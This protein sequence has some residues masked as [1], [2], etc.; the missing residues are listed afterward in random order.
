MLA[1]I[2]DTAAVLA[3][4]HVEDVTVASEEIVLT[5]NNSQAWLDHLT[6]PHNQTDLKPNPS[7]R[8]I[9]GR[10]IVLCDILEVVRGHQVGDHGQLSLD[11]SRSELSLLN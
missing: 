8:D 10:T 3:A 2:V 7:S 6:G 4:G 11:N 9:E 5:S 1:W